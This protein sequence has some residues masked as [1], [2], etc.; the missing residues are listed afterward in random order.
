MALDKKKARA[1]HTVVNNSSDLD[2]LRPVVQELLEN[3]LLQHARGR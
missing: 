2:R 1:D 3:V